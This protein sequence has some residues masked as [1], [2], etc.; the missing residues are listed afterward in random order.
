MIAIRSI[1]IFTPPSPAEPSRVGEK[2]RIPL[3]FPS[4]FRHPP[5]F[6]PPFRPPRLRYYD[7]KNERTNVPIYAAYYISP[8][9]CLLSINQSILTNDVH[10]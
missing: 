9:S 2:K 7:S 10:V 4:A 6:L 3:S 5:S 1:P 8:S